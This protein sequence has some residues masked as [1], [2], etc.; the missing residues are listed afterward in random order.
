MIGTMRILRMGVVVLLV[1]FAASKFTDLHATFGSPEYAAVGLLEI[2]LA[3]WVL[4]GRWARSAS[5][6]CALFGLILVTWNFTDA[7]LFARGGHG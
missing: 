3:I 5:Y 4:T 1:A 7:Q 2:L 6:L